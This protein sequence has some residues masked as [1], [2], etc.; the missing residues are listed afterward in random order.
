VYGCHIKSK[1]RIS[2]L[3]NTSAIIAAT[4]TVT[5]TSHGGAAVLEEKKSTSALLPSCQTNL[6]DV[7]LSM[8]KYSAPVGSKSFLKHQRVLTHATKFHLGITGHLRQHGIFS[9]TIENI[10]QMLKGYGLEQNFNETIDSDIAHNDTIMIE[11]AIYS[12]NIIPLKCTGTKCHSIPRIS[13]QT[14][15][16]TELQ[17]AR[18]YIVEC[19]TSPNC[20]IWDFS[21]MNFEWAKSI[22][23]G[24][25][26]NASESFLIVPHMFH[27]RLRADYHPKNE[28]E[29]LPYQE[30]SIDAVFFGMYSSRRTKFA[31][32]YL[33]GNGTLSTY[34]IVFRKKMRPLGA[35]AK[36]YS[37]AKIC[38][39]L[40]SYTAD[41]AGEYHRMSDFK[42]FGCVPIMETFGDKML[43]ETLSSCAGIKFADFDD[44]SSTVINELKRIN[45]TSADVLREEQLTID[46]WWER[47]IEWNRFLGQ[48]FGSVLV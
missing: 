47:G 31:T 26:S 5:A 16:V 17:W 13:L 48:I 11:F 42:R 15:Q 21:D 20:L 8:A 19:H 10:I 39:V 33:K 2:N 3:I 27:N 43:A 6:N 24:G 4:A 44:I 18:E 29:L 40:H 28:N 1:E 7:A 36:G 12:K 46:R 41:S 38:L 23:D 35:V 34:N 30:R 14:E 37:N 9:D 32:E 22:D 25:T 45:V